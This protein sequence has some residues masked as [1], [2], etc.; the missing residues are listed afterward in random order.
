MKFENLSINMKQFYNLGISMFIIIGLANSYNLFHAWNIISFASKI[1]SSA[2]II[3]NFGLAMFFNYLK[4]TLPKEEVT[5]RI[6][7]ELD[8]DKL[9]DNF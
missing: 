8:V 5:D 3:F 6:P 9:I 4:S 2:S 7:K 1:S